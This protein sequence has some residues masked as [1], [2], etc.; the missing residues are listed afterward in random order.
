[1][2]DHGLLNKYQLIQNRAI[3]E[4]KHYYNGF[5]LLI[6]QT[7]TSCRLLRQVFDG[8]RLTRKERK[9]VLSVLRFND[10]N[11]CVSVNSDNQ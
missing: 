6:S 7:G 11:N 2:T 9:Q 4:I 10:I 5:K 3:H 1:M 8:R